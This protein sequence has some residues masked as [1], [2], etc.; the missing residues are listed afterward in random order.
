MA[1]TRFFAEVLNRTLNDPFQRGCLLVNSALEANAED[2]DLRQAVAEEFESIRSF[3]EGRLQAFHLQSADFVE[4]DVKQGAHHLLSVL[5]GIRV[6]SRI[7]PDPV[8]VIDAIGIAIK[9]LGLPPLALAMFTENHC[10]ES[11]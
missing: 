5:L 3:F 1:I 10:T 4:I 6:L 9:S 8:C 2:T 11:I 7:N